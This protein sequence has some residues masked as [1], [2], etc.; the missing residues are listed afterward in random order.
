ML[1]QEKTKQI[2]E[3]I[4]IVTKCIKFANEFLSLP[5]IQ[6]MFGDCP[7]ERFPTMANGME[8]EVHS[9]TNGTI[10]INLQWFLERVDHHRDDIEFFVFHELRHF[11]QQ[12]QIQL[13]VSGKS[14]R[15]PLNIVET[16]KNN[17]DNYV[18]NE[19]GSSQI[20]NITQE[21]E[22]D[23]NAYGIVLVNLYHLD[24]NA[25][26]HLSIPKDV[27]EISWTRG[28]QYRNLP[29]IRRFIKKHTMRQ[30]EY[31]ST[32]QPIIKEKKIGRNDPCPCGS[33]KK[34]KKCCDR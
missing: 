7:S 2:E 13:M 27:E 3:N 20:V 12:M 23:A 8:S 18:R 4:S 30:S 1:T 6:I 29:E 5:D 17:F 22:I 32:K 34:Y 28:K 11:Y 33:G 25:E 9:N 26:I 24:D 19:G 10:I 31:V 21:I 16:W 14:I 15:E